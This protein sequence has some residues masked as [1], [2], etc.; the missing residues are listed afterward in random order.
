MVAAACGDN[1]MSSTKA[2][3][4][5]E[6]SAAKNPQLRSDV[7][8]VVSGDRISATLP[9]G[10][11]ASA[12]VA[13]YA[14]TG[15]EVYVEKHAQSSGVTANNF[16]QSLDYVV[17]AADHTTKTYTV[18]V[19]VAIASAKALTSFAF[20]AANNPG[21]MNDVVAT[22]SGSSI[23]AMM[24]NGTDI[25]AL[26][27]T[28]TTTGVSVTI[29]NAVQVSGHTAD[30]FMQ[31]IT[32]V[33]TGADKSTQSYAMTVQVA[34]S[35]AKQMMVFELSSALNSDAGISS[36]DMATISA[37]NIS[38]TVP[39]G[40][41][42]TALVPTFMS[43]GA[44]VAI[45]GVEQ[46]SGM[47]AVNFSHP[48]TYVV[49]ASDGTTETFTVIITVAKNPAKAITA[50]SLTSAAN[51]GAG[52]T[53]DVVATVSGF[54]VGATVP[55]GTDV[56]G[57]VATF[58]TTG[59]SV[60]VGSVAQV[61]GATADD[62]SSAVTYVVT[63]ADGS[64]QAYVVTITVSVSTAKEITAFEFTSALNGGNGVSSDESATIAGTH[65]TVMVPYGTDASQLIATFTTTGNAVAVG[66]TAQQSSVTQNDF[67][68]EVDYTVTAQDG[69]TKDFLVDV[70]VAKNPAKALTSF[71]FASAI[72]SGI[73]V[74]SDAVGTIAG[75]DV[76]VTVPYG[77]DV[78]QLV[79]SFTTT[80]ADVQVGSAD[81]VS[82][83]TSDDFTTT[84][85]YVVTA[86]DGTMQTY[87]VNVTVALNPAKDITAFS[88][89]SALNGTAGVGADAV[90][91][92]SGTSISVCFAPG[93]TVTGLV[94][95]FA[96]TG[97]SVAVG[98]TA[99]Q[100]GVTSNDFTSPVSYTVT[101]ADGT[102]QTYTVTV[103]FGCYATATINTDDWWFGGGAA[104]TKQLVFLF[105]PA[106]TQL[107][108]DADY[109]AYCEAHGFEQN[110]NQSNGGPYAAAGMTDA[111][112]YY[113][114][115]YC[116][117]LGD[118]NGMANSLTDF[119]NFGLP[120]NTNLQ[121]FDRGCGDY[122][123]NNE[124]EVGSYNDGVNTT[125]KLIVQSA[126]TFDY[127]TSGG[128]NYVQSKV[129]TFASDGVVVCQSK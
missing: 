28:F 17:T 77:T 67:T 59:A 55:F 40:T 38:M 7:V 88:F 13:T 56:T 86:A 75:D 74:S 110:Q 100:S 76:E 12:L 72:N 98:S 15:S 83:S 35:S 20:L 27:P 57:L 31:V 95:T 123:Y 116:C 125:D 29:G 54:Q 93:V 80:G 99:Q 41:D 23:G 117:Y 1:E 82:G 105:A 46:V 19:T 90:G 52:I 3:T 91:T 122:N 11:D 45:N 107:N 96:T 104:P 124:N 18:T 111:A 108:S 10:V 63:A 50:F 81:Q 103:T 9:N 89:T 119:E 60:S 4:S 48:V 128:D 64:T 26:V 79:A 25:T 34:A 44:M 42:V 49:T 65:I 102:T 78:T 21:L 126:T 32:V 101:A 36:N 53:S 115:S 8:A 66:S 5:F 69:S 16:S 58:S 68:S 92:I 84:V 39:Y 47:S 61:S 33:V 71:E 94:A 129:T 14:T 97:A 112:N 30:N 24:P 22:I 118:G 113:C 37:G 51:L 127:D 2:I 120:A 121:V 109:K 106:G 114:S 85:D 6:F 73:G 70:T 62:F 87:T 43:S